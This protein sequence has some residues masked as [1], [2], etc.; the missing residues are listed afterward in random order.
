RTMFE[1]LCSACSG[2]ISSRLEIC[3]DHVSEGVCPRCDREFQAVAKFRCQVCKDGHATTPA[4]IAMF[5]PAV[6]GFYYNHG[7]TAHWHADDFQSITNVMDLV[8]EHE[9]EVHSLDPPEVVVTISRDGDAL[10]ITFDETMTV[11][12]VTATADANTRQYTSIET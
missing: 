11:V 8:S 10:E 12:D 4:M 2:P 3:S 5:H 6:S 7:I 1:G 9:S